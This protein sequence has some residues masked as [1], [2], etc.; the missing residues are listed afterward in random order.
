MQVGSEILIA[1]RTAKRSLEA[2]AIT[3]ANNRHQGLA[4]FWRSARTGKIGLVRLEDRV[5]TCIG[6]FGILEI[7]VH[8]ELP[9]WRSF[10]RSGGEGAEPSP[11][12]QDWIRDASVMR[13]ANPLRRGFRFRSQRR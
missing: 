6:V 10:R 13:P 7:A 1:K 5:A 11:P 9:R 8:S 12:D 3:R 4:G 2:R